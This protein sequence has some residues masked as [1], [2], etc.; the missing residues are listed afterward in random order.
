[1]ENV[2]LEKVTN[3]NKTA[4]INLFNL[5]HHDRAKFL[6]G[7]YSSVDEEG[8]YDKD[9]SLSTLEMPAEKVQSYLVKYTDKI[10]GLI[11]FAFPPFVKPGCDYCIVDIFILN[12]Y[13]GKGIAGD[14]CRLLFNKFPGRYWI[15]VIN[16]DNYALRYW[17]NLI[18]REGS[19]IVRDRYD[20]LL[21]EYEFETAKR[22]DS[23][24]V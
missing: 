6:P 3:S 1:M 23:K 16:S 4:F 12:N 9:N 15:Q 24:N 14:A 11:V 18:S 8:Y 5:Y 22:D 20:E 21:I 10:A 19:L 2:K 7:M 13:R 17:D